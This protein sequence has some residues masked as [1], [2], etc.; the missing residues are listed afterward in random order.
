MAIALHMSI[1]R[2]PTVSILTIQFIMKD[3]FKFINIPK[4]WK[5]TEIDVP[6]TTFETLL[7]IAKRKAPLLKTFFFSFALIFYIGCYW[8][9]V[10]LC[11][12]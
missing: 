4:E 9:T 3:E 8:L 7:E 11:K 1:Y 6:I 10:K 12:V 2:H 5:R